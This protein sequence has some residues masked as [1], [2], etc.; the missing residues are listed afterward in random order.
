MNGIVYDAAALLAA[1]RGNRDFWAEHRVLLEADVVPAVPA[2]V[3]VQVS[4][5]PGQAQLRRLLRGCEVIELGEDDAHSAGELLGR[6]GA[7]DVVGAVVA[8][9]TATRMADI[10]TSDRANIQRL[11]DAAGTGVSSRQ[12]PQ[13]ASR[14]PRPER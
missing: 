2:P 6:A 9:T 11:L 4:R 12:A 7:S 1:D 3:I 5:S 13:D 10:A 14:A 8:H